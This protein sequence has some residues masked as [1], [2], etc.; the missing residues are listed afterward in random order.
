[1]STTNGHNGHEPNRTMT[2]P[3]PVRRPAALREKK[4][5]SFVWLWFILFLLALAAVAAFVIFREG[6]AQGALK[7]STEQMAVPT[8]RVT[9]PERG[10]VQVHLTLPGTVD[11]LLES[12]VYAQVAGYIK[13]W[14]VDIGGKVKAGQLLAEI[15]TPVTDQSLLQASQSVNQAEA[16]LNLAQVTAARYNAL[17]AT[18]AVS[19]E[20]VDTQNANVKVQQAN[21]DSAKAFEG[22]IQKTEAFKQVRAPFDGVITARQIDVGDYVSATGQTQSTTSS[23][24]GPSQTGT[25]NQELFRVAQTGTLRVYV[26][27]PENYAD[28]IVPGIKATLV[29]ASNPNSPVAGK[30]VRTA[31]AIDPTSLTLLSEV[32]VDNADGKLF[33][34]GYAQVHF[35]IVTAHPPL[36]IPGN[37]LIFRAQGPQVGIVDDSGAVHL[38]NIKIGRDMGTKLEI[39]DG[40]KEDDQV[41]VNPSDSLAD[42]QKVRIDTSNQEQK[43]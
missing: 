33:P 37:S 39:V 8:V 23:S 35:D 12:S 26:N 34:G 21:V 42:G 18:H 22:G 5:R 2:E 16:N 15:D 10:D 38:Q 31:D 25:P 14:Y 17:L 43:P 13:K 30:L 7:S 24:T 28:E 41:I 3:Q 40:L 11:A 29:L 32:D 27:V 1:M 4:P 9:K 36:V 6:Q 20:D 19:Q